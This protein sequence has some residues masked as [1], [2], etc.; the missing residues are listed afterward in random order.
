MR[1]LGSDAG[2]GALCRGFGGRAF[3]YQKSRPSRRVGFR[4]SPKPGDH[5]PRIGTLIAGLLLA[6]NG[7]I[8]N[9]VPTLGAIAVAFAAA[10]ARDVAA[11]VNS[12]C[13]G[14]PTA[15]C[16]DVPVDGISYTS[17]VTTVNVGDGAAGETVV[18][19]GR[20]GIELTRIGAAG[21]DE[22]V[23][24][25]FQV[26]KFSTDPKDERNVV[27]ADGVTPLLSDGNFIF[28]T[29]G[30]PPTTF[31]IGTVVYTGEALMEFL[32]TTSDDPGGSISGGLTVNNNAGGPISGAGAPFATTNAHGIRVNSTSNT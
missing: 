3:V 15:N 31:T 25:E 13:S 9:S 21:H 18:A 22:G 16:T 23:N 8:V 26:I 27:S 11:Q 32:A 29:G 1:K 30:P 19:P 10:S 24:V 4:P 5:I 12:T 6:F 2:Y 28:A 14:S 17:G 20:I 7:S